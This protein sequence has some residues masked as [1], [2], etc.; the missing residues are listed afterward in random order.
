[1]HP[2]IRISQTVQELLRCPIC[3]AKLRQAGQ[4]F[5]CTNSECDTHFPIVDGI[6]V[7]LNEQSS[8][9]SLDDFV[10]YRKTF[11]GNT[12]GSKLEKTVR[13]FVPTISRNIKAS[14]NYSRLSDLLLRQSSSSRILV[15]GGSILGQGMESLTNNTSLDLVESDVSFG[16]RTM[17]ICDAHDIPFEDGTFDGVIVQAVLE[18][19]VDPYRCV[20]EIHRVLNEQGLVYAETAFMQQVHGGRYDFTRFTHLGHRRLFRRFEEIDSGAV[21]GP[22]MA[23]AWSYQYFLLSFTTSRILRGLARVFAGLTSF[24]LKYS[25]HCLIDKPGTLDAAAGYYYIGRKGQQ[26]LSDRDLVKLYK[27]V[28]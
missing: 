13:R 7:L 22:G 5:E 15:I 16:P 21:G 1:M 18:H 9:F 4:Q 19:V 11:F 6:P 28:G 2:R 12:R 23:L 17:L 24:Y 8:V 3:R 25:D 14:D 26:V 20:E 10:S 27:G